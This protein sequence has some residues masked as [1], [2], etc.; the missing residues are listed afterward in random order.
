MQFVFNVRLYKCRQE[1]LVQQGAVWRYSSI[2]CQD[3]PT[4]KNDMALVYFMLFK[5][6]FMTHINEKNYILFTE[7]PRS[8]LVAI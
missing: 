2:Q 4:E 6:T 5:C 3:S 7:P 8:V 1:T